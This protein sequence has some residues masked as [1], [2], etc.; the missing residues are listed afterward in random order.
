MSASLVD[1]LAQMVMDQEKQRPAEMKIFVVWAEGYQATG[2]SGGATC[3]GAAQGVTFKDACISFFKT[4]LDGHFF[5]P[6]RLTYWG[7]RLFDSEGVARASY[8]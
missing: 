7:C 4:R 3:F 8:G 6:E 5:D 1:D 2:E